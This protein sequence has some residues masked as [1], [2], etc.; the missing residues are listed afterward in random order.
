MRGEPK[1]PKGKAPVPIPPRTH[2]APKTCPRCGA[3]RIVDLGVTP[4]GVYPWRC[5]G[6][7][8]IGYDA[9]IVGDPMP[10]DLAPTRLGRKTQ[11]HQRFI[12]RP[13]GAKLR[14]REEIQ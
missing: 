8:A 13:S 9:R 4:G 12:K 11:R 6:C 10:V 14:D 2:P 5:R 1:P 7:R 3:R